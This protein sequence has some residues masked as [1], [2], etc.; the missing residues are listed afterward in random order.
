M[1]TENLTIDRIELSPPRP[2]KAR[3]ATVDLGARFVAC[4]AI[5]LLLSGVASISQAICS[6]NQMVVSAA[7]ATE[8]SPATPMVMAAGPAHPAL[9]VSGDLSEPPCDDAA[10]IAPARIASL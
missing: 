2:V 6:Y 4:L 9:Q 8:A 7:A 3:A 5:G 10:R 1:H